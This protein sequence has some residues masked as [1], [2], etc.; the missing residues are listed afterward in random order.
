MRIPLRSHMGPVVFSARQWTVAV[1][2]A[3]RSAEM[4]TLRNNAE[5]M[6][7]HVLARTPRQLDPNA[8]APRRI[9]GGGGA[10]VPGDDDSA[11]AELIRRLVRALCA[12]DGIDIEAV[13]DEPASRV[14]RGRRAGSQMHA[15]STSLGTNDGRFPPLARLSPS[16]ASAT[17]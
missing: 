14:C 6:P 16:P 5:E 3:E 1:M 15:G 8:P 11:E 10:I 7:L 17:A 4:C 12:A 13:R 9:G 2:L